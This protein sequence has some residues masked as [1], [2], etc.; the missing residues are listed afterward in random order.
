MIVANRVGGEGS[1]FESDTN[2][3]L[4]V[5]RGGEVIECRARRSAKLRI[6]FWARLCSLR[7]TAGVAQ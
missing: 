1:G 4:L 7:Q 6:R 3:V 5:L 2:E